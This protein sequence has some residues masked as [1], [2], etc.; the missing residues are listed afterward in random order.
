MG[1]FVALMA[2]LTSLVALSIDAML[3]ALPDI[4]AGLRVARANDTQLVVSLLFAG[5]AIGQLIYGPV[6]D[7]IGRRP[8]IQVG[9]T[10]FM[11]GSL[12]SM[13]ASTFEVMLVG[14]LLQGLGAAGPR[15][16]TIA[17]I[18]DQY[19]GR[20]MARMMSFVMTLFI[21]VPA[22]APSLGQAILL[23]AQWR[24]IFGIF[25][26]LGVTGLLWFTFRQP[27]T[28]PPERRRALSLRMI[29]AG[30]RETCVNRVALGHTLAAGL[31]LG[32]FVGYLTTTQQLFQGLYG[33]GELFPVYF[34]V[35]A[36]AIGSASL[37][38][39]RLVMRL[40]MTLLSNC[41][42]WGLCLLSIGFL[43]VALT[44]AGAPP[45]WSLMSYLLPSFFCV[46]ILFGNLQALAMEPLGHIAG[47][48][49]AVVGSVTTI[50]SL[51]F[52]TMIG[53]AYDGTVLPLVGG[54]A[55]LALIALPLLRW[56][57][58]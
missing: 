37:S 38:N 45:L 33:V 51:V 42:M 11:I 32:S 8:A 18:R 31:V 29:A 43:A 44:Q 34:G 17:M 41:A 6:S 46:G 40:G 4:G 26:V 57:G 49:A 53:Q 12:L 48:G 36:L 9:L 1:E 22:L 15:I 47:V 58:R 14:R 39:A 16:V 50:L 3:P 52:G 20:A 35:L 10:L 25:L 30:V 56:A 54:F 27:E 19:E 13:T 5:L 7:S 2:L 24:A 23:I 55:L 21:L 28:H